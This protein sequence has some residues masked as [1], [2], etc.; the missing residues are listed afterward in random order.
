VYVPVVGDPRHGHLSADCQND[1]ENRADG[2]TH[3]AEESAEGHERENAAVETAEAE[4]AL[5]ARSHRDAEGP[6]RC[7]ARW[8]ANERFVVTKR[9]L[10]EQFRQLVSYARVAVRVGDGGVEACHVGAPRAAESAGNVRGCQ[11]L[12][13]IAD[14]GLRRT[15]AGLRVVSGVG[16][17]VA[18][19]RL[20]LS[21]FGCM[22]CWRC[23][24]EHAVSCDGLWWWCRSDNEV[25]VRVRRELDGALELNCRDVRHLLVRGKAQ[26]LNDVRWEARKDCQQLARASLRG[27]WCGDLRRRW[28][29]PIA[30]LARRSAEAARQTGEKKKKRSDEEFHVFFKKTKRF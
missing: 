12:L 25:D 18:I 29:L 9:E 26:P 21:C 17:D 10:R 5:S 20:T 30:R 14:G 8:L 28:L 4:V 1:I 23:V 16:A 7:A 3:A 15:R 2:G 27:W 11:Q 19:W 6:A 24:V 22:D 13:G